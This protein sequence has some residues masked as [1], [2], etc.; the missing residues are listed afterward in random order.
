MFCWKNNVIVAIAKIAFA[1]IIVTYPFIIY[2]GL[3]Q[4]GARAV[5]AIFIGTAVLRLLLLRRMHDLVSTLPHTRWVA[6]ALIATCILV[7]IL[8]SP[9]LLRFYPVVINIIMFSVFSLSLWYP[10]SI[11]ERI[12][13]LQTPDLTL[14]GQSYTR[15]VTIVW[16]GFFIVNGS[17]ALYTSVTT[18]IAFWAI[19]NGAIS[20]A[21]MGVLFFGEY[22][23]RQRLLQDESRSVK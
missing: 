4:F 3:D 18:D 10:P 1:T 15:K 6:I 13:R 2:F 23:I 17:M 7:I 21:M 14:R 8:N 22:V 19:Y 12:A 16:C 9:V 11:V 5:A 20:Y